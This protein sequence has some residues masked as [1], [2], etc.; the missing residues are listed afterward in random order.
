M[1]NYY[2][3][4]KVQPT[5]TV[6]EIEAALELQ[7]NQWRRLVTHHDPTVANQA[8]QALQTLE[9][10]RSTLT[11]STRRVAYDASLTSG[12]TAGGLADPA[13]ADAPRTASFAPFAPPPPKAS[14]SQPP[15]SAV[16]R[17]D[18][19]LCP[20]CQTANAIGTRFCKSCGQALSQDCPKC[21]QLIEAKIEFCPECGVNVAGYRRE[22]QQ[23][24]LEQQRQLQAEEEARQRRLHDEARLKAGL[25]PIPSWTDQAFIGG[26]AGLVLSMGGVLSA[27]ILSF[28]AVFPIM[29]AILPAGWGVYRALGVLRVAQQEG[30]GPYRTR[31]QLGLFSGIAALVIAAI[32][33]ILAIL[34][35]I[36]AFVS[37]LRR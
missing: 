7:Y 21:G 37:S 4:L 36:I 17:I 27:C 34:F 33:F 11:D 23:Q 1:M 14:T 22:L 12:G 2:E 3:A 19:W 20:K 13:V 30:I 26:V 24:E 5:A 16:Q 18:A 29:A 15:A 10:I 28:C 32:T 8:N 25:G 35:T 31:A 6:T 9:Q